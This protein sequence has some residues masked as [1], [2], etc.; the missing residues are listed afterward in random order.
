MT[1][2]TKIQTPDKYPLDDA[3]NLAV[4]KA[5]VHLL[6]NEPFFG[7]LVSRLELELVG[8]EDD[9][10]TWC[11][12]AATDGKYLYF[13]RDFVLKC[14][15]DELC[16]AMGHEVLHCLF[17][18][19]GRRNGREPKLWNCAIDFI[20][21]YC[22]DQAKIG[23]MRPNWLL[24]KR[25]TDD[26]SAEE[27]YWILKKHSTE[28]EIDFEGQ[29]DEHMDA[30]ND[31]AG[32]QD[33]SGD[34]GGPSY[35]DNAGEDSTSGDGEGQGGDQDG[36]GDGEGKGDDD[37]GQGTGKSQGKK[38]PKRIVNREGGSKIKMTVAGRNGKP[39]MTKAE[40]ESV[41]DRMLSAAMQAAQ[42]LGAGNVPAGIMRRLG[43][44][45]EPKMN[46]RQLLDSHIRS[47][48]KSGFTFQRPTRTDFGAFII[49][50]RD[51]MKMIEV[52]CWVDTSGSMSEE[53]LRD[54]FSE[55]KGIMQTFRAFKLRVGTFDTKAYNYREFT[56][57]NLH[58]IDEYAAKA[59]GGGGTLFECVWD[60]LK[61]KRIRPHR[62]VIFTD[63]YPNNSWGD[64]NYCDTLFVI[65]GN[66][67][68][69]SQ[70]GMTAYYED[71]MKK[72]A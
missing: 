4:M 54:L 2:Q 25:F 50:A 19:V 10:D 12:T 11:K 31:D 56:P 24:D 35:S 60:F 34:S 30:A 44:L 52:D 72:A 28:Y 49:P 37:A 39:K 27:V 46:W 1:A 53:Q 5:S 71:G 59:H 17:D 68:I 13:N 41:R 63:G 45:V 67:T 40:V 57:F 36:D 47:A 22:L 15:M 38:V 42:A 20:V 6:L 9:P 48:V 21:N 14:T 33:D 55:I 3:A 66:K 26:M 43:E 8:G 16:F 61:E 51:V 58:E 18:H 65:H 70:F 62:L 7:Q 29:F 69:K 64:P 23:K 32:G